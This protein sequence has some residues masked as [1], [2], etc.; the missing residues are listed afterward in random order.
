MSDN[1]QSE[2]PETLVISGIE[3]PA[4]EQSPLVL[5]LLGVI[6]KQE[7][8][9][10][11]LRDEIQRLKKTTRRPKIKP[12]RL[13][14]PPPADSSDSKKKRPGSAKRHKTKA[15]RID[16]EKIIEPE[17]VPAGARLEEDAGYVLG[18]AR[19]LEGVPPGA[20]GNG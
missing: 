11:E 10:E 18:S 7:R 9:I 15:L 14:K 17:V 20:D 8:E 5:T 12:S 4:S 19:E 1:E 2:T 6:R 3:I 16:D 13:L